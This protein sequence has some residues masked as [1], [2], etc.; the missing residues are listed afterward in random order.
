MALRRITMEVDGNGQAI[1][2]ALCPSPGKSQNFSYTDTANHST[3]ALT[4]AE[5]VRIVSTTDCHI[6]FGYFDFPVAVVTDML[7]RTGQPEYFALR[8]YNCI[9]AIRDTVSGV[10]NIQVME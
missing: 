4:G 7:I 2:G 6:R 5:I 8:G 10:L 9:S 1:Q 3:D